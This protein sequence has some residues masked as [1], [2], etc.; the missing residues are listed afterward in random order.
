M[1]VVQGLSRTN[2]K[3]KPKPDPIAFTMKNRDTCAVAVYNENDF[4]KKTAAVTTKQTF[5]GLKLV[6][7]EHPNQPLDTCLYFAETNSNG[8]FTY[9]MQKWEQLNETISSYKVYGPCTCGFYADEKCAKEA[10]LFEASYR[11]DGDLGARN[12]EFGVE[13]NDKIRALRC[14]KREV[15]DCTVQLLD[16]PGLFGWWTAFAPFDIEDFSKSDTGVCTDAKLVGKKLLGR[17]SGYKVS[18][19]CTCH[20]YGS[21]DCSGDG[22][23]AATNREHDHLGKE[24]NDRIRSFRCFND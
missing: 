15:N 17:V 21:D 8:R 7:F 4:N 10:L 5:H 18:G 11:E 3:Q 22:F 6:S 14:V 1:Q 9:A 24:H 19:K 2:E 13:H 16:S 23:F 12:R 20:F